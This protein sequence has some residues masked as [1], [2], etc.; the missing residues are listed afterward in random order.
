MG[1]RR[2][3][4]PDFQVDRDGAQAG[5]HVPQ[6]KGPRRLS[7]RGGSAGTA[8]DNEAGDMPRLRTQGH[9][10][11]DVD[12][13]RG[14]STPSCLYQR[15]PSG[16]DARADLCTGHR[17]HDGA[18]RRVEVPVELGL[19][20]SRTEAYVP[21]QALAVLHEALGNSTAAIREL[22]RAYDERGS[23][24]PWI[25][26]DPWLDSLR[27]LP[28]FADILRRMDFETASQP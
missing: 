23:T 14:A 6:A 25:K 28:A 5:D 22:W 20:A 7:D 17:R 10:E 8:V 24:L 21:S 13:L 16:S 26:V 12:W 1:Q 9:A 15:G 4:L 3:R 18:I 11:P 2:D 27:P 19:E